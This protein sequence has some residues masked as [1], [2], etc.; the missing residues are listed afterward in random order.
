MVFFVKG[1]LEYVLRH[2]T[3][4]YTNSGVAMPLNSRQGQE[5]IAESAKLGAMGLRGKYLHHKR[6]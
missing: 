6:Y 5:Y 2:C 3:H 1:A 4:Y